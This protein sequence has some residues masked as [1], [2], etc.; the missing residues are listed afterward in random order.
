MLIVP[1]CGFVASCFI[2]RLKT[3][4]IRGD[5][6]RTTRNRSIESGR[7]KH[8]GVATSTLGPDVVPISEAGSRL[9][10]LADDVVAGTE[11]VLTKDG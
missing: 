7:S 2:A 10:T 11:K 4:Y 8:E 1:A 3:R 5:F 9:P 6:S